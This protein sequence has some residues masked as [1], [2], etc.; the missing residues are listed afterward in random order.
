MSKAVLEKAK[1]KLIGLSKTALKER[2]TEL[3]L[4]SYIHQQIW[5][6]I[7]QQG[8][9]S[10]DQFSTLS[11]QTRS[12]LA[13]EFDIGYGT[14]IENLKSVDGTMK[15]LLGYGEKREIETVFIPQVAKGSAADVGTLCVSSQVGCSLACKF[16]HTGTQKFMGNLTSS[17][18]IAQVM[19][20]MKT[21]GDLPLDPLRRK[22][23][24]NIVFMGQG[25]PLYN[26]RNVSAAVKFVN[27]T[28]G[29]A[30]WRTTISTSGLVPL[31]PKIASELNAGL[32]VS[33]HAC[34]DE[35]RDEL[36]PIN[37]QYPIAELMKGVDGYMKGLVI[38]SL[39]QHYRITFEYV[40]LD[41]VN[42][43]SADARE[44]GRLLNGLPAHVNLIPFN[45]W[46]NSPYKCSSAGRIKSFSEIIL[47]CR[48]PC[49]IRTP[50]GKDILAA[51]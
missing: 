7:Y 51:W 43:T 30:P 15:F 38:G 22:T 18:I 44:L 19:T 27:S 50:R 46:P 24:T 39:K 45:P 5:T 31:M 10:F 49:T 3:S 35:L 6:G 21:V 1:T 34:N 26:Y 12:L 14:Q 32:A 8:Y 28:Y 41:G 42:D 13:E 2:I 47:S 33:L 23:M 20:A 36:V 11:K 48:I 25:E 29:L 9:T 17:E 40:M 4:K 37:K 16:C